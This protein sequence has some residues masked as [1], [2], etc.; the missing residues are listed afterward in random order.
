MLAHLQKDYPELAKVHTIG[1]SLEGRPLAVLEIRPNV[2]RPRPLLMPMFKYVGNMHGDETVGREMLL[3][4]AQYL[5]ANYGR[6]PEVGALMNETAIYLMPTMNPDGYERSKE[7]V[8]ESPPDYVGRYN[9]ANVDL[10]RDF[11]DRFDDERTRHVRMKRR[12]P[13]TVAVMSWI[14]NNPFVLSANLHGGAVV[15]SYPYDNSIYHHE[16]CEESRTPDNKFFKYAALTYAENHP[17]MRLGRDCNETF[18]SGI[19]NGAFWYELSGGMQDF[20]YVYSNCFEV[21]L[22]L[23]C[24]KFPLAQELPKEWNK[25]KR[26]LIE[27][28]K[29]VHVGV[30][31][32]VTDSA[33]YPIKDA[34]V[35]VNGIDRNVRTGERG[36]YW[37]LL[38]PGQYNVRVEAVGYHPSEEVTV[39]VKVD[40]PL[41]VNF[42][43][44]SYDTQEANPVCNVL[45]A[46]SKAEQ[47]RVVR[48]TFDEY[49][50]A[51][52]PDFAHHNYTA[53][54]SLIRDLGSNY[55]SITHLYS[56]GKSVQGRDLWVMEI[57]EGPGQHMP[58]KP[59]V[60]YIANMHGNEVVGRELLLLFATYLCENYNRTERVTKLV[61][62]TR[63]HL[64]FSMNPDGYEL[65]DIN[66]KDSLK[67]RSNAN[68]VDLNRNF[69]DQFGQNQY[70]L[71]QEPETLAVMNWSLAT[72]FV[73]SANLHG[74]ALVA[75]YPF[76][77]SPKDFADSSGYG[78]P[79]TVKNPTEENELFQYLAHVYANSHTTMHLGKPCPSFLRENFSDGITN[80]ASWYS[81]TGGMQDWSYVVGGAYELTLEVGCDKFPPA[82][83]LPEFWHQN[84]E[85]LLQYV[86]QA[87][88]GITGYVRS[89]IGHPIGRAS[90]QVDQ[91][92]HVTYTTANGDY[93]RLL[94]PGL[95][96][97]TAE[98]EGYEP[99]KLEVRVSPEADRAVIVDFQLMRNDPQ[100][101]S[102]AYDFRT[103]DNIL[104]TRYHSDAELKSVMAEFENKHY[105]SVTLELSGNEV[106]MAYPSV[107]VTDSIASPDETKLHIL[108]ISS[109][110]QT[111]AIG[112]EMVINLARHVLAGYSIK[113]PLHIKLLEN[114]VLHFVPVKNDFEEIVQQF[115]TNTSICNPTLHSDELADKL[116]NA[117]TDHQKDM[118][119][120]MLKDDEYDLALT[121]AAGGHDVF[122]PHTND[123]VAIY[124]RFAEKI[125]GHK[126]RQ[127]LGATQ[128]P[129]D[130]SQLHQAEATQR[131]TNTIQKLYEVPMFTMQLGCCKMPTE[132]N[133]ATV[134]R[135]NLERMGNFLRL[136][137]TGIRG[138]VKDIHG[139]PLRKAI[140]RVR[141]N[142]LI[143]KVT[144]NLAH[145]RI[146]LPS[147]SIEIEISC[148]NYTSRIVPVT[149][150][151]NQI[152]D[153]GD[154]VMQE[155]ARPRES[156][157]EP[158]VP[159]VPQTVPEKHRDFGV[160]EPSK[161]MRVF[162][163][164]G[165]VEMNG[166]VSGI[167]LDDANHPLPDAKV[168]AIDAHSSRLLATTRTGP[169]GKFQLESLF[170]AKDIVV[171][172]EPS[173]YEAGQKT[174]S[175]GPL[176]GASGIVFHLARDER[177]LGLPRL[178]FVILAGCVCVGIIVGG[179]MCFMYVQARR[180]D[181][182][183]YYNFSLLPQKGELNR[184]LFDDDEETELFRASTKKLQ[185][186]YDDER[187]P[188]TDTDDDSEEE[189][190]ML[191]PS[192]RNTISQS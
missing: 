173:G 125:K 39:L 82:S 103:L 1:Q 188:I 122:F 69:P 14:L 80:G 147:G 160:L 25:N 148:Y 83:Q 189:I 151:E 78:D 130:A 46:P 127:P 133:I 43:L 81:V 76:D 158:P 36:E 112:R 73:L 96:N 162:P 132:A 31:G 150:A 166:A 119:L 28:M 13:E 155:A 11:P 12:Q 175:Q 15:A 145:F 33:G 40:Q 157:V 185:P 10:N 23:S 7:G 51:K 48:E 107:K 5:L 170:S 4:L 30:K 108:I 120:R 59:E 135:Q 77:D 159:V 49:G 128:C 71:R 104:N 100:H 165:G 176:G 66:D 34:D 106:S 141:G 32:L 163:Q 19:T 75:N 86:E 149:L 101:W 168:Y 84:R 136:I 137:D 129:V 91:I 146:V 190:V 93:Y 99:Q 58:G 115:R 118:F 67:G 97:V 16:C 105:K 124:S 192:F 164:D 37:R 121:F 179:I 123:K 183:Y 138:Y 142:S 41:Q 171:H 63:L 152:L 79:R 177:V 87:Q 22:E 180:R 88:H 144:P 38:V 29:L 126:Y 56:I 57:T 98:A 55:P 44:K 60:K 187:D 50:F 156:I 143:Y 65:A 186:Y 70:N 172:A 184:K 9:A 8:C 178:V 95:Y 24:C 110:F 114:A 42:S 64:L 116:L 94:L 62:Q 113:E 111:A 20:N 6:D 52:K 45:S 68:N 85:A 89:T 61:R 26:S 18:Q 139:V 153:L 134:W 161:T 53:M 17:V 174:I 72:P 2:N 21:T 191:N 181:S 90:V 47:V 140:L 102:S 154:I 3:Y 169:L 54:V 182:R 167:V 92:E 27:Y 131:V 35:I 117:E 109:L 74:G